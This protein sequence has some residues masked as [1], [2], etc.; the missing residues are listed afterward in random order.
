MK[1]GFVIG[2]MLFT[3]FAAPTFAVDYSVHS[4][5]SVKQAHE[6]ET[7]ITNHDVES[8]DAAQQNAHTDCEK[9]AAQMAKDFADPTNTFVYLASECQSLFGGF[10]VTQANG[11]QLTEVNFVNYHL[12]LGDN[13]SVPFQVFG[14]PSVAGSAGS[15]NA[16]SANRAKLLDPQSGFAITLPFYWMF[17]S[18][19]SGRFCS[20]SKRE[21]GNCTL[22]FDITGASKN[23]TAADG[24]TQT[25]TQLTLR[26]GPAFKFPVFADN[27]TAI[28]LPDGYLSLSL[29]AGY[30]HISG[31]SDTS[32]LFM[33]V[34]DA[35]GNPVKFQNSLKFYDVGFSFIVTKQFSVSAKLVGPIGG[36]DYLKRQ[37][38]VS[39][40]SNF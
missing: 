23:L 19:N 40:E 37:S 22:G 38:S 20:F 21:I 36:S 34:L 33:P 39:L 3:V 25:P 29:K 28:N 16:P 24:T 35:K 18:T 7:A 32:Q 6:I 17:N 31:V 10:S 11:A 13:L 4:V 8:L 12:K 2:M 9:A 1:N 30:T 26:F 14:S 15:N 27:S 5:A